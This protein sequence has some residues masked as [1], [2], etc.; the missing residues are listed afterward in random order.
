[1]ER[2]IRRT[3]MMKRRALEEAKRLKLVEDEPLKYF[4]DRRNPYRPKMPMGH[5]YHPELDKERLRK[6]RWV[7]CWVLQDRI[8]Q[9][10]KEWRDCGP[11]P[12]SKDIHISRVAAWDYF[13]RQ[14]PHINNAQA[15]YRV[16]GRRI[17]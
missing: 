6:D 11:G 5:I 12:I 1:M 15:L 16:V 10:S 2:S 13:Q 4:Q 7:D 3:E 14:L 9:W 17:R 8:S